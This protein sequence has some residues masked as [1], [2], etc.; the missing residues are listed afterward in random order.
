[1]RGDC[2][3]CRICC[4]LSVDAVVHLGEIVGDPACS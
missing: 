2:E 3:V 1:M 4:A